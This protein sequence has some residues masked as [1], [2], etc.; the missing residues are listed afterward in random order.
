MNESM[1]KRVFIVVPGPAGQGPAHDMAF[2]L[3][4]VHVRAIVV[5]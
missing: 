5:L 3:A 1:C 2:V 4:F